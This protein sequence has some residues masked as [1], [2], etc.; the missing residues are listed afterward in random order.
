MR[1]GFERAGCCCG[2][3]VKLDGV[4][5]LLFAAEI[6]PSDI[7][8]DQIWQVGYL[9]HALEDREGPESA[10]KALEQNSR[11]S[12]R[13]A[14]MLEVAEEDD[15][16]YKRK[17]F[18]PPVRPE[19]LE[20]K[21]LIGDRNLGHYLIRWGRAASTK[22]LEK[23]AED[24]LNETEENR[25]IAYL[26]ILNSREFARPTGRLLE[27][28]QHREHWISGLAVDLLSHVKDQDVRKL[29]HTLFSSTPRRLGD[30]AK[31][32]ISN[33]EVGDF[34]LIEARLRE[35]MGAEDL[36]YFGIGLKELLI[37]HCSKETGPALMMLYESVPCSMCRHSF[38]K[39]LMEIQ[40]FPEWMRSEC[41]FDACL[42]TRE[43]VKLPTFTPPLAEKQ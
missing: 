16:N 22:E 1:A 37:A 33:Y 27:L 20:L 42:D 35:P 8:D 26:K 10:R 39:H 18:E 38:V 34:Q 4:D 9:V 21:E 36:H 40:Q 43:L 11:E 7:A 19:F 12:P 2:D 28:A 6:F 13:L 31:L 3:L 29:A 25:I 5:A 32:L 30:A 24:L 14:R 17:V 15:R 41:C 23:V